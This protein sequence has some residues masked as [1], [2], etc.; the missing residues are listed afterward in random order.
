MAF[1]SDPVLHWGINFIKW[2]YYK[3]FWIKAIKWVCRIEQ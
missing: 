2:E 3:E 1:T